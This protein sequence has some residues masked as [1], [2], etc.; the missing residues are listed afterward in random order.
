MNIPQVIG[1][2]HY[3]FHELNKSRKFARDIRRGILKQEPRFRP[4]TKIGQ[5]VYEGY[6]PGSV[7]FAHIQRYDFAKTL[8]T[9]LVLNAAAGSGYGNEILARAGVDVIG[10]D[11]YEKP[12]KI[13]KQ[14]FPQHEFVQ[15][16][17]LSLKMFSDGTFDS[18]VSFETIEHIPDPERGVSELKRIL[19]E[20]G[21]FIGSIPI[22]IYHNPGTNFTYA[23]VLRFINSHFPGSHK[24]IQD[25]YRIVRHSPENWRQ[26]RFEGNKYMLFHWI[27]PTP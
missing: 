25:N 10:L 1:D 6:E 14:H 16:N 20:G 27:K 19:K 22:Q 4:I 13:A 7:E 9:G 24:F 23:E 2:L 11:L 17:I 3:S 8:V 12:L 26:M 5:D 18:V 15:G 21:H